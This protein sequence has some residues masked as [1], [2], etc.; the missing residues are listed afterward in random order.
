MSLR[1]RFV[2]NKWEAWQNYIQ[3][4]LSI[5]KQNVIKMCVAFKAKVRIV[6]SIL[7]YELIIFTKMVDGKP[8]ALGKCEGKRNF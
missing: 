1:L 3:L 8:C 6:F 5:F 7:V 4:F 2:G